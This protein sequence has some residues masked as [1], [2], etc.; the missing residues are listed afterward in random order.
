MIG[1]Q[2]QETDGRSISHVQ[3]LVSCKLHS[4]RK[5]TEDLLYHTHCLL[6]VCFWPQ[7]ICAFEKQ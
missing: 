2:Y 4:A 3:S 5:A 1:S 6:K 7:M